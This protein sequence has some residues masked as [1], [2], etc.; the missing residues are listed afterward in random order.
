MPQPIPQDL[1]SMMQSGGQPP[2]GGQQSPVS[3]PMSTPQDAKGDKG[4]AMAQV[5]MAVDLLE[6]TLPA[7]GSDTD[8]GRVILDSLSKLS[9]Q[10]GDKKDKARGL[11]PSEIMNLVASLPKGSGGGMPPGAGAPPGGM[12]PGAAPGAQP[13]QPPM[14]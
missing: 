12:P 7:F 9:K 6:Q 14:M 4:G 11:I 3:A 1:M 13:P 10:F 2:S 5:Q 8:E